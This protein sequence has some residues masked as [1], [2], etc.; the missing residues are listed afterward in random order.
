[1]KTGDKIRVVNKNMKTLS[2][3]GVVPL[4]GQGG[5]IV[6]TMPQNSDD[7]YYIKV[8]LDTLRTSYWLVPADVEPF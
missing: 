3:N 4:C 1:M 8:M 7:P 2:N 5:S 6:E